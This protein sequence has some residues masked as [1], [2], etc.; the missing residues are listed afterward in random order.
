MN[1]EDKNIYYDKNGNPY[2]YDNNVS[3]SLIYSYLCGGF[4]GF[5]LLLSIYLLVIIVVVKNIFVNKIFFLKNNLWLNFSNIL[6]IYIGFRGVFE[7]SVSV[8]GIDYIFFILAYL[9]SKNLVRS[10]R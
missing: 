7:N 6:M 4:V 10:T 3:N 1:Y 2:L 8:F 5:F 9:N